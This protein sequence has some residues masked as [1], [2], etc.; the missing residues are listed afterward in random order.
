M[1]RNFKDMTLS[2][3][4]ML[5]TALINNKIDQDIYNNMGKILTE[6]NVGIDEMYSNML[7]LQRNFNIMARAAMEKGNEHN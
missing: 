7:E 3:R 4:I 1:E 5:E 2:L 6:I